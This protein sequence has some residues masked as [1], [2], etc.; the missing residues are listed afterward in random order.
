MDDRARFLI[1]S[2]QLIELTQANAEQVYAFWQVNINLLIDTSLIQTIYTIASQILVV[3]DKK[4]RESRTEILRTFGYLIQQFPSGL[5]IVNLELA[6]AVHQVCIIIFTQNENPIIWASTQNYLGAAYLQRIEGERKENI[7]LA[8]QAFCTSLEVYTQHKYPFEWARTQYNLGTVY[9]NRIEGERKENIELAIQAFCT[10]LEVYTQ[11]KYPFEWARTQYNLGT[12]YC[13]RIEGERKENIE[14]AIQAFC[15]SLEVYTQHK[16][17]FEWARTQYNLGTVYCNRLEGERK[18]NIELA[19][20][21]H[22][23]SLEIYTQHKY[24][25]E[26]ARTQYGLGVA[27]RERIEGEHKDNIELAIQACQ[28]SKK[29]WTLQDYLAE[30][31]MVRDDLENLY[32]ICDQD[33]DPTE[34][35]VDKVVNKED[36]IRFLVESL[37]LIEQT[38][39]NAEQVY[40]FWQVNIE[41]IDTWLLKMMPEIASELFAEQGYEAQ[42]VIAEIFRYFGNL[43]DQFPLG[44]QRINLK[45]ASIS[46][47]ISKID[48]HN[49]RI[50]PNLPE[51]WTLLQ[52]SFNTG[53]HF[54]GE[55]SQKI[56]EHTIE[57]YLMSLEIFTQQNFPLEWATIQSALG[58]AYRDR[59]KGERKN[60]IELAIQAHQT[61]LEVRTRQDFP[62]E[63]AMTQHDLGHAYRNRIE[64]ERKNNIELAIQAYQASMKV[65]TRQDF[66]VE[67]ATS[68]INLGNA[69]FDRIQ[70]DRKENLELAIQAYLA[71][72]EV[73]TRQDFPVEWATSQNN[74][75]LAYTCHIEG[76]RK[77]NLELAIQ[78]YLASL[79]IRTWENFSVE[80]AMTQHNLGNAYFDRIQGDRKENLELAI[81]AYLASLEVCTQKYSPVEWARIQN[82]LGAAYG[83]R[84]EGDR[85]ENLEL[86]IQAYLESLEVYTQ[87]NFLMQWAA[88]Q[89]N[90]SNAY[91][92]RIEGE[93]KDNIELAIQTCQTLLEVIT[94]QDFPVE[95]AMTQHNLGCALFDRIQGERKD[96]LELAIQAYQASMKV[97]TRQ[98]FPVEWASSQNNLGLAYRNRIEEDRKENIELAIQAYK[99]ALEVQQPELMPLDCR[100]TGYN[101]GN[102][103]FQEGD[104]PIAIEG[105]EKAIT[106]VE[107]SR[108]WVISDRR[109]Q[110]ILDESIDIYEKMLQSCINADRLD[111]AL[112]TIERI[113]SKRLTDLMVDPNL[114]SQSEIS[115]SVQLILNRIANIQQQI[116]NFKVVVPKSTPELIGAGTRAHAAVKLSIDAIHA[117]EVQKQNLLDKLSRYDAV[118]AQLVEF[119]SPNITYIQTA[120]LDRP[121]VALLSFYTTTQDTHI[122]V[123]RSDSIQCFTCQGQGFEQIQRWLY[124]EWVPYIGDPVNWRQNMPQCLQQ[125]A[126]KLELDR[127][128]AD[129]LQD[130][131]E[132]ILIPH[133]YL[134]LIPFAAMPLNGKQQ[135]LGDRF[136]LRYAPGCQVLKFCTD[137]NELPLQQQYGTVE[138]ATEDLPFAQIEGD[139]IARIFQ[140]KNTDRLRGSQ[141]ATIEQYKDLLDRVN[142]V[143]SCHH[144]Q[145]RLDNP[146]ESALILANGRRVTLGDLLSPAWRFA[147]LNDVFLSCCETGMTMPKSS[148]DELLT[149]GTG[150]LCAGARGVISSLWAV[151]DLST[152]LFS[153]FYHQY[154]AQSHDRTVALQKAQQDLRHMS[155]DQLKVRSEAEFLPILES[156][157]EQLDQYREDARSQKQQAA[158]DSETYQKWDSEQK[159]YG[160]LIDRITKTI[161]ELENLWKESLP[162]DHPFYWAPFTCQ[163]LR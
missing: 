60:N 108:S 107:K 38:Q 146:L 100:R 50:R 73:Y 32:A 3:R 40:A 130:V 61:S 155:G 142:S 117:L 16:Y 156:Q 13:N 82:N 97:Y 118:S 26:W 99:A 59:I 92:N 17:P 6:I 4:E 110:E 112:Q 66:S 124:D 158:H 2:L 136:L 141:Q 43:I 69:Y 153:Q 145:S 139:A 5:Q 150:F 80:W 93:R 68:Q 57:Y 63:W 31:I 125:L 27:Y 56:L 123:V 131:R 36:R 95:W 122:L 98:D 86:A 159:R 22:R 30:W 47:Q 21:A 160:E 42:E 81:Q 135:Y 90:L 48:I 91:H 138:N 64:G 11:H 152:A 51:F 144:A 1:D 119:N 53:R 29:V 78:A 121:D 126:E 87:Q 55:A 147:D 104:W 25:S 23:A 72:L 28:T 111:L 65:Y 120:L 162:F 105:F 88:T 132:L 101:L 76:E 134:H 35:E 127:L 85:K 140:V 74:L 62:V 115:E 75:G 83:C 39:A 10:S 8:I 157:Q 129:H 154:R 33:E 116:D 113:R 79:E 44:S 41:Q 58:N 46:Y 94:R 52:N 9:C 128:V 14:L 103:A 137:R 19:I 15:T 161:M 102:L 149:L 71:S 151:N 49:R 148:T 109:R 163:G 84:I 89:I 70:G 24:S 77:D 96:N 37:Q 20:Q 54:I 12:V 114:Y 45:L 106:A 18:E 7:E 67:W 133:L 34:E 143:A